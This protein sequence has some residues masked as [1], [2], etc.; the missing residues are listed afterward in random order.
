MTGNFSKFSERNP[1]GIR[2]LLVAKDR[3]RGTQSLE[4]DDLILAT[5][6]LYGF[7]LSDKLWREF[8]NLIRNH[9]R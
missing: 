1:P 4:T 9:S 8:H 7:S 5:P 2:R 3:K 6:I